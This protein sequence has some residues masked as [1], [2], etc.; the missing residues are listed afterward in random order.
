[1]NRFAVVSG[2]LGS[3]KT[4]LMMALT[5]QGIRDGIPVSMI[6]NDL[7]NQSLADHRYASLSGCPASELVGECICYQTENLVERLRSLYEEQGAQLVLSDIPGFG[8][9]ALEHVYHTLHRDYPSCCILS[10]FTVVTEPERVRQLMK[11]EAGDLAYLLDTQL[12]EAD[13]IV[14]NKRDLVSEDELKEM[15]G[16]L[17]KKYPEAQV[18]A[19]SA[20]SGE[21]L[22]E[23]LQ[24]LTE[25]EASMHRPD[26]GYGG[27]AFQASMS[28]ISEYYQQYH[29]TVCC[30]TFDGNAYLKDLAQAIRDGIREKGAD[31]PHLKLLAFS[32]DGDFAKADLLGISREIELAHTFAR[33][34]TDLGV[35]LN[36]SALCPPDVLDALIGACVEEVSGKY[37]LEV[38]PFKKECFGM[39]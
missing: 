36:G 22:H 4:T 28:R 32:E 21:G 7:G 16:Y 24:A 18:L 27:E 34:C 14:L 31:L 17:E 25:Q 1:M 37:Q 13:L 11:D 12:V 20:V 9:G 5:R 19:V 15:C 35:M 30:D 39:G 8:V 23:L 26:I 3:G 33:P 6:S 38:I 2:F 10:P 29:V